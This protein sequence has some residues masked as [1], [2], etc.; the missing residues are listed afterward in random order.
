M[1]HYTLHFGSSATSE[2]NIVL[3]SDHLSFKIKNCMQTDLLLIYFRITCEH[4]SLKWFLQKACHHK[5]PLCV[6]M[7]FDGDVKEKMKHSVYLSHTH[8]LTH[9]ETNTV[10]LQLKRIID[11]YLPVQQIKHS[12]QWTYRVDIVYSAL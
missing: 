6:Q 9:T 10:K 4:L 8:S 11:V 1:K 12:S 3:L 2:W 5:F 7:C